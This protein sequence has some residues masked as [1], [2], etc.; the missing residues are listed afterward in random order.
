MFIH[1][2]IGHLEEEHGDNSYLAFRYMIVIEVVL[3]LGL[4]GVL[5]YEGE[6][7]SK[8]AIIQGNSIYKKS[9][10]S[11]IRK[12]I[13]WFAKEY[14][15][16]IAD[17]FNHVL[18]PIIQDYEE[19]FIACHSLLGIYKNLI[20][21]ITTVV[22]ISSDGLTGLISFTVVTVLYTSVFLAFRMVEKKIVAHYYDYKY[23]FV[24]CFEESIEGADY[25]RVFGSKN[26]L[27][28]RA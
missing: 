28:K 26:N 6:V 3:T 25:F 27:I 5:Y 19:V 9:L 11:L 14:F 4:S 23:G 7:S 8:I 18:V 17:R 1:F 15:V 10:T 24:K 2:W 20:I 13:S 22:F 16:K 21:L 12:R